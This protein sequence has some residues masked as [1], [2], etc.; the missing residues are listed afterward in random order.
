MCPELAHAEL[1]LDSRCVWLEPILLIVQNTTAALRYSTTVCW[2]TTICKTTMQDIWPCSPS[3][4]RCPSLPD[5]FQFNILTYQRRIFFLP[6]H[7]TMLHTIS[8]QP[9]CKKISQVP[10]YRELYRVKRCLSNLFPLTCDREDK[11][12]PRKNM[13]CSPINFIW[14]L[15]MSGFHTINSSDLYVCV[16]GFHT[17]NKPLHH[18]P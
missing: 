4:K 12:A 6:K 18:A 17:I 9:T 3:D 16:S 15:C 5:S 7:E 8:S 11:M 2:V 10:F 1:G 13:T 14:S